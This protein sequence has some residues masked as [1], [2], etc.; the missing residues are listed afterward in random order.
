MKAFILRSLLVLP[1]LLAFFAGHAQS[2]AGTALPADQRFQQDAEPLTG[3][4]DQVHRLRGVRY[5]YRQAEFPA[6][7]FPAGPQLGVVAQEVAEIYP[8]LVSTDAQGFK[9]VDY[10]QL[11][12]LLL[13]AL[14]Q[15]QQQIDALKTQAGVTARR[16]AAA[17]AAAVQRAVQAD[18]TTAALEQRL[19][20]LEGGPHVALA[21]PVPGPVAPPQ[22]GR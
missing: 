11:T 14:K 17:E 15:Q 18:A 16:A 2:G 19:R 10:A 21:G 7:H 20:A 12:P 13:E 3:V 5:T 6:R 1:L 4:L 22:R 9:T 8:E